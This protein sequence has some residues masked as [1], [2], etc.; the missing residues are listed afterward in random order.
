MAKI[1]KCYKCD[2]LGYVHCGGVYEPPCEC[3]LCH[4][5]GRTG[6]TGYFRNRGEIQVNF[7][8]NTS[9]TIPAGYLW[10]RD[11]RSTFIHFD[12]HE[13]TTPLIIKVDGRNHIIKKMMERE[14]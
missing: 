5:L 2:G 4:G 13:D 9:M 10:I 11:H 14:E 8:V 6:G 12:E 3:I 7:S 1:E